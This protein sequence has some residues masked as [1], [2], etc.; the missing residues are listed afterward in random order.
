MPVSRGL[1]AAGMLLST[2]VALSGLSATSAVGVARSQTPMVDR[3]V[4][5][6]EVR[7][8]PVVKGRWTFETASGSPLVTPDAST[9]GNA[10]TLYGGAQIGSGW[11]DGGVT[12][13]GVD[14]YGVT[15]ATPVDSSAGFTISAWAQASAVPQKSVALLSMP[16][17]EQSAFT[18]LYV[19]STTPDKDPGRWRIAMASEDT[20][21]ATVRQVENGRF[22]SPTDWT[23]VAL[24][25]DGS[26]KHLSLYVN[27]ELEE[28]RC[29]DDDG[30]GV[31]DDPTCTDRFSWADDVGSFES[32]QPMQLGRAKTGPNMWGQYWPGTV[33]DVWAFQ[34][35]LSPAQIQMLSVGMPGMPTDVPGGN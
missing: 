12:L 23:H 34:G 17:E 26:A 29:A 20:P 6:D 19:P 18:V 15:S 22:F 8:R 31:Q 5:A 9:S 21:G 11:V 16:G 27:G 10:M 28:V 32:A 30:D 4:S 1:R 33:S 3:P 13:D 14:D 24:V 7:A 35:A 25:Y 2:A